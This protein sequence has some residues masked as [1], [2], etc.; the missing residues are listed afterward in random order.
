MNASQAFVKSLEKQI[1]SGAI[2]K[3]DLHRKTGIARPSIDGYLSGAN[4][5][6]LDQAEKIASACGFT[7]SGF[8][9]E[10]LGEESHPLSECVRRVS[11]AALKQA[12]LSETAPSEP[13]KK[14]P[15]RQWTREEIR[16]LL[17]EWVEER[18]GP[19]PKKKQG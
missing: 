3:S 9:A 8:L 13:A 4:V 14:A 2:N 18:L 12:E 15:V 6:G 16:A 19:P 11:Q 10:G 17:Q 1:K 7:L 5:P